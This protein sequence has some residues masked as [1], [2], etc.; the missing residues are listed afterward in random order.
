LT[1]QL[2]VSEV[3]EGMHIEYTGDSLSYGEQYLV[4]PAESTYTNPSNCPDNEKGKLMIIDF[5]NDGSP[6][7]FVIDYLNF[8]E[9]R[10]V[11]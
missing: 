4:V 2:V 5:M 9:W 7:Y 1:Y 6:M 8:K 11:S 3:K 10:L